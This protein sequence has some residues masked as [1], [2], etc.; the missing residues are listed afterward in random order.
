MWTLKH[1]KLTMAREMDSCI[2]NCDFTDPIEQPPE[3]TQAQDKTQAPEE[4]QT[5]SVNNEGA[6]PQPS[7]LDDDA[8][9]PVP[10]DNAD[11]ICRKLKHIWEQTHPKET[12]P[13]KEQITVSTHDA[14]CCSALVQE[15]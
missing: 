11:D 9:H 7:S 4:T 8:P 1:G 15:L 13:D 2:T 10:S 14:S 5:P 3:E 6:S 12:F